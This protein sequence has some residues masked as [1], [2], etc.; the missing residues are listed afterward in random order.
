MSSTY[1]IAH[2]GNQEVPTIENHI[3]HVVHEFYFSLRWVDHNA[4]TH[5]GTSM[6]D[7]SLCMM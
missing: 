7:Y 1:L 6:V 2:D 3:K 5:V 4:N